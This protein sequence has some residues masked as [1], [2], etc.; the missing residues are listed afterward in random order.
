MSI[1]FFLLSPQR[2]SVNLSSFTL[3]SS[4]QLPPFSKMSI[5]PPFISIS[6]QL[7]ISTLFYRAIS[8]QFAFLYNL[9]LFVPNSTRI[10]TSS[11]PSIETLLWMFVYWH[12]FN[13]WSIAGFTTFSWTLSLL[14]GFSR[15][16]LAALS[17][18]I[19]DYSHSYSFL[20]F[21]CIQ[22]LTAQNPVHTMCKQDLA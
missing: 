3:L 14:A 9:N 1:F 13:P 18:P 8:S 17:S 7:F 19:C 15:L 16:Q 10:F 5:Y 4:L 11:F 20:F 12:C 22:F 6:C 2:L 21:L